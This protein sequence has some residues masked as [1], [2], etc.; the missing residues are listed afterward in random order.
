MGLNTYNGVSFIWVL[1]VFSQ[2]LMLSARY[3]LKY[4][5]GK[6]FRLKA[7]SLLSLGLK[8]ISGFCYRHSSVLSFSLKAALMKSALRQVKDLIINHIKSWG[9]VWFCGSVG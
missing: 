8:A 4:L 9:T 5:R 1:R 2:L 6:H 7:L 3:M